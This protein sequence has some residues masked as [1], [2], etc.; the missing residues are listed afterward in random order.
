MS[1]DR[2]SPWVKYYYIFIRDTLPQYRLIVILGFKAYGLIV[3]RGFGFT[4]W[5]YG[6]R[7]NGDLWGKVF[8]SWFWAW[9]FEN[10]VL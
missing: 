3:L 7:N 5:V 2:G 10:I 4:A 9:D 1:Q 8:F 6:L